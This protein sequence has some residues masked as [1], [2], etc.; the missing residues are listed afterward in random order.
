MTEKLCYY[1]TICPTLLLKKIDRRE[2]IEQGKRER[3]AKN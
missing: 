1:R 2:T 3:R